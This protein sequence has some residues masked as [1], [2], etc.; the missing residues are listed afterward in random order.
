MNNQIIKKQALKLNSPQRRVLI[1]AFS[2]LAA[3]VAAGGSRQGVAQAVYPNKSVKFIVPYPA[4]GFPDTVA[5][6]VSNQLAKRI[7]VGVVVDNKP[8]AN[9]VVAAQALASSPA[10]GYSFLV[11]DGSMFSI[12]PLIYKTLSYDPK[13]DFSPVSP[14]ARAPLFWAVN[15]KTP[16][17]TIQE[18]IAL[19]KA[20]PGELNYG[21]SGIGSTHHL[22]VEAMKNILGLD[23]VHIPF[24][25]M[26]QAVPALVGGQ[27]NALFS[28][29]PALAGFVK[30]GQVKLIAVNSIKRSELF[31]N[32]PA[33]SEFIPGYDFAPTVGLLAA[34]AT[35]R[36]LITKMNAEIT[37]VMKLPETIETMKTAGIEALNGSSVDYTN[38]IQ[39][40]SDRMVKAVSLAA[41]K[42]E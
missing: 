4:G 24:K 41:I 42:P 9:G 18:F 21:S 14:L 20:K 35:P 1:N 12:N 2:A 17:N 8:G 5:R 34:S 16:A 6:I 32:A 11:T 7:G 10:D 39:A 38:M 33:I 29:Y 19:A 22:A 37:A 23:I 31:P 27:V 30:S 25:G 36:D 28:A 15:T 40:E 26:G 13:K 3:G